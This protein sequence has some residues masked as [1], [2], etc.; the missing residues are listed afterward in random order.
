M[1]AALINSKGFGGNNATAT[2]LSPAVTRKMLEQKH[3]KSRLLARD[4]RNAAVEA[5]I[6]QYDAATTAGKNSLIYNFGVGVIEGEQ[7]TL[8]DQAINIPGLAQPISM[9]V[10]NPYEDMCPD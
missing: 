2:L 7:L 10:P 8:S 1:D 3:G 9:V 6:S 4:E 5:T